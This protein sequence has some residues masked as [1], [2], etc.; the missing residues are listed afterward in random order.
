M[1]MTSAI[2]QV[3]YKAL[4]ADLDGTVV[5]LTNDGSDVD[6][7]TCQ[8]VADAQ[9]AGYYISCATGRGWNITKT[10]VEA[11]GLKSLCIVSGGTTIIDAATEEIR[12]Q[13]PLEPSSTKFIFDTFKRLSP[14]NGVVMTSSDPYGTVIEALTSVPKDLVYLYLIGVPDKIAT[15]VAGIINP[16]SKW[17]IAH[18]TPSWSGQG[19]YDIHVTH[20][21]ATKEHAIKAWHELEGVTV[22]QTIGMGDSGNDLP[23][24]RASGLKVAVGNATKE[25][26]DLADYISPPVTEHSLKHVIDKFLL[27]QI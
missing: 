12:W 15:E 27:S 11:L 19:F 3:M 5:P 13:K 24:F 4:I 9:K 7:E 16:S 17:A 20:T 21:E 10:V 22:E 6:D 18:L 2:L 8:S 14:V 26:K 23:L 1:R 25:L